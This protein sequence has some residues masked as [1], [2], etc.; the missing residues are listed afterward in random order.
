MNLGNIDQTIKISTNARAGQFDKAGQPHVLNP[1][2][3]MFKFESDEEMIIT[4][5]NDIVED[6]TVTIENLIEL[7]CST[8]VVEAIRCLTKNDNDDFILRISENTLAQKVKIE[9]IKDNLNLTR[10][11]NVAEKVLS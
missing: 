9:D 8:E 2:R 3:L 6:S 5:L 11:N 7:N 4:V 1:F 10:L